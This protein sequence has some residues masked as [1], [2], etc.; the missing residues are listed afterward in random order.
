MRWLGIACC[1]GLL[2]AAASAGVAADEGFSGTVHGVIEDGGIG[3]EG[4]A[5][6]VTIRIRGKMTRIDT[7]GLDGSDAHL[8]AV[9]GEHRRWLVSEGDKVAVP[10]ASDGF[11]MRVDPAAPCAQMQAACRRTGGDVVAGRVVQGWGYRDADGR[12]PGNTDQ[13]EFWVDPPTGLVLAYRGGR[14]DGVTATRAFRA[15][16]VSLDPL[17]EALFRLPDERPEP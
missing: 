12:G 9:A 14:D 13:G 5:R 17:P 7:S 3:E 16:S 1:T 10:V 2:A 15:V 6:A 8:L 11:R 4:R